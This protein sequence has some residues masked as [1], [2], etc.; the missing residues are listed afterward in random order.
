MPGI[1]AV[2]IG[3]VGVRLH[4]FEPDELA[5]QRR[6]FWHGRR[7]PAGKQMS[8]SIIGHRAHPFAPIMKARR[9]DG[10]GRD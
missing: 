7:G 10:N 1:G 4:P 3:G 9:V 5:L 6:A 8:K 2:Q